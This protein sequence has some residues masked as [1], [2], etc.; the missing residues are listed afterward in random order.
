MVFLAGQFT[1][2]VG[3]DYQ[4][5]DNLES[6]FIIALTTE[7][8]ADLIRLTHDIFQSEDKT[9]PAAPANNADAPTVADLDSIT[10][11]EQLA[12]AFYSV[13]RRTG[14]TSA[15]FNIAEFMS[16]DLNIN[17]SAQGPKVLVFHTHS[18]EM[19]ADSNDW[20]EGVMALG[21]ELCRI[22]QEDYGIAA[23]H[24]T[25]R[26]GLNEDGVPQILGAYER[27][28]PR[29]R[30]ILAENPS[31][32]L[33]IDL[34][35]DGVQEDRRFVT[36][37]NG[38][39]TAQLMFVNGLSKINRGGTLTTI[40]SLPNPNLKTNLALSFRAQ[41]EGNRLYPGLMRRIYLNAYRYSLHML[42]K[43]VLIEVGA[44]TNTKAEAWN[45]LEPLAEILAE[46]LF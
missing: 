46:V 11:L 2:D 15:D 31:I 45:A 19:F 7:T 23:L 18:E 33:I 22:L 27:M 10:G 36:D 39:P 3:I 25:T 6:D 28:E 8:E 12:R 37:I 17:R 41:L 13:D 4:A 34:H 29:I 1:E 16:A 9:V 32:E 44:Q 14:M 43:S 24:D 20:T 5:A 21:R 40:D 26:H 30:R 35:R 38:K 42:P